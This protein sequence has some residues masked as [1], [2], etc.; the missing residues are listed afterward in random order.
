MC[1]GTVSNGDLLL[2]L[3]PL[4]LAYNYSSCRAVVVGG[5]EASK[6]YSL[7]INTIVSVVVMEERGKGAKGA[8]VEN[9][10]ISVVKG[11]EQAYYKHYI[12]ASS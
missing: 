9:E 8:E 6:N 2:L 11:R 12:S 1:A 3:P 5:Q 10:G 7:L 4:L